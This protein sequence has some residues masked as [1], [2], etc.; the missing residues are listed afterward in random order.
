MV[1][2]SHAERVAMENGKWKI[3]I[4]AGAWKATRIGVLVVPS[5]SPIRLDV[6]DQPLHF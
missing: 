5:F 4:A 6:V 3:E 2:A 1:R